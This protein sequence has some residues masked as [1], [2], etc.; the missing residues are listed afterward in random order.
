MNWIKKYRLELLALWFAAALSSTVVFWLSREPS[1]NF[2]IF[3]LSL[4]VAF[5]GGM[6]YWLLRRLWQT[7][8]RR[9]AA[10][11][12]QKLIEGLT[13][14][15]FRIRERFGLGARRRFELGG[16]TTVSFEMPLFEKKEVKKEKPR[17]W[18]QLQNGKERVRYLYR[19]MLTEKIRHGFLAYCDET[20]LELQQ[21][22]EH[23]PPENELF[24]LYNQTRY[25]KDWEPGEEELL[26]LKDQ[27]NIK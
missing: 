24:L 20:P 21:K 5:N 26:S 13:G 18:K 25:H 6:L 27:L 3:L 2:I 7:K 4:S 12:V 16:K 1:S 11:G 10:I 15:L 19:Q 14:L 17:K 8:W 23:E 22:E 9:I